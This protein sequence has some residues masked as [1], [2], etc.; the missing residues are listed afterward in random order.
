MS[1]ELA[2]LDEFATG[3]EVVASVELNRGAAG[4]LPILKLS[5]HGTWEYGREG[6][7]PD[8][9]SVWAWNPLSMQHGW[10]CWGDGAK[11]GELMGPIQA[12]LPPA[13]DPTW[14]KQYSV[15]LLC[16]AGPDKDE[17]VLY[18]G[19]SSGLLDAFSGMVKGI[20]RQIRTKEPSV[21]LVKLGTSHYQHKKYGKI[22]K[23]ELEVVAW[24]APDATPEELEAAAA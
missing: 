12:K 6:I 1:N 11:E 18:I 23:P 3:L 24:V 2:K 7:E 5:K 4:G 17:A 15:Q 14:Q 21:P 20:I 16:V 22:F 13:P 19:T 10:V 8:S 9:A